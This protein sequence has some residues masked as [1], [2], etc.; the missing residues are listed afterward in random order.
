M[1]TEPAHPI[2]AGRGA[3]TETAVR[4]TGHYSSLGSDAH[5]IGRYAAGR[6]DAGGDRAR[7]PRRRLGAVIF[8]ADV[9]VFTNDGGGVNATL[10]KNIF[11]F[12]AQQRRDRARDR[13]RHE[14]RGRRGHDHVRAAGHAVSGG[15]PVNVHWA[16][17]PDTAS[18]AELHPREREPPLRGGRDTK[19][20]TVEVTGDTVPEP[21]EHFLV[22]LSAASGAR[23]VRP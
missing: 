10:I 23:L 4:A 11:A 13:R 22:N 8:V 2:A 15:G 6:D 17:A 14:S 3:V 19:T 21:D 9:D 7:C 12:A 20:I 1:I 16:T 5:E 18:E